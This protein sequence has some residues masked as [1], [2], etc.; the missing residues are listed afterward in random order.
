MKVGFITEPNSKGQIVI[1]K[2]IRDQLN[3]DENTHLNLNVAGDVIWIHPIKE[4][5]SVST[6]SIYSRKA[7]LEALDRTRGIWV[8]DKDFD[9]RQRERRR[10]ELK[11]SR[12]R[13]KAWW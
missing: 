13:K 6:K 12:E 4:V 9:K 1:P 11:A 3:I 10:M 7:L 5:V 8:T 2:K